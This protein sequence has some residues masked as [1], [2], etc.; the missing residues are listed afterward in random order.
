MQGKPMLLAFFH[1][2]LQVQHSQYGQNVTHIVSY[3][4]CVCELSD[5][6]TPTC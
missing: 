6:P 4:N 3:N 5:A 2:L 1:S